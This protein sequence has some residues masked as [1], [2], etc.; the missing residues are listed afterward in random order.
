MSSNNMQTTKET[1]TQTKQ[2]RFFLGGLS[3]IPQVETFAQRLAKLTDMKQPPIIETIVDKET[4][5][6]RGFT[7]ISL[8]L[9]PKECLSTQKN[10]LPPSL[11][12]VNGLQWQGKRI[13]FEVA[14]DTYLTKF[15]KGDSVIAP[16]IEKTDKEESTETNTLIHR[17]P[18]I[19]RIR[20]RRG[21]R[22]IKVS[23]VPEKINEINDEDF[24]EKV[25]TNLNVEKQTQTTMD[26]EIPP[27]TLDL[28]EL[29]G[30]VQKEI[31]KS[32][33]SLS[34]S[35][36]IVNNHRT[37]DKKEKETFTIPQGK[38]RK[39]GPI[40][41]QHT[42]FSDFSTLTNDKNTIISPN[43]LDPEN[44]HGILPTSRLVEL[45]A[46]AVKYDSLVNLLNEKEDT[47]DESTEDED[48]QKENIQTAIQTDTQASSALSSSTNI[49]EEKEVKNIE[50]ITENKIPKK[51]P[52]RDKN[53]PEYKEKKKLNLEKAK[54][55]A[56][57]KEK[58]TLD[59][60]DSG[61]KKN[62]S[63]ISHQSQ[64]DTSK[65]K[66]STKDLNANDAKSSLQ[67]SN[68]PVVSITPGWR[69]ILYG[70]AVTEGVPVTATIGVSLPTAMNQEY[71]GVKLAW[72]DT[73][74]RLGD[75]FLTQSNE[76]DVT[77]DNQNQHTSKNAMTETE[78]DISNSLDTSTKMTIVDTNL[79][80]QIHNKNL[81]SSAYA[82]SQ[83]KTFKKVVVEPVPPPVSMWQA[84]L[85][86]GATGTSAGRFHVSKLHRI[87]DSLRKNKLKADTLLSQRN[88]SKLFQRKRNYKNISK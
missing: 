84:G 77:T 69:S 57:T 55:L 40:F 39:I 68:T 65:V 23:T 59:S 44:R 6:Y 47:D 18:D 42:E 20:R 27:T 38:K 34:S 24:M 75:L 85:K 58:K 30:D 88:E 8:M 53:R 33:L 7:Y 46:K 25:S 56:K 50:L 72:K 1:S 37:L 76:I 78:K 67:I 82:N 86:F 16:E 11:K 60:I 10:E 71:K 51:V 22:T 28:N 52:H 73:S 5:L 79:P 26:N 32:T 4:G 48:I 31:P 66:Q 81:L 3:N 36:L 63:T 83:A 64:E 54:A 61:T 12:G 87:K 35:A 74:F 13:R 62:I 29:W 49:L 9:T 15:K 41:A 2:Q 80:T 21:E 17:N 70:N 14:E 43:I 19:L 45:Q